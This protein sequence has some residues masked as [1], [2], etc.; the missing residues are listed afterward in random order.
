MADGK[1][2]NGFKSRKWTLLS[3]YIVLFLTVSSLVIAI[4]S[5]QAIG[6]RSSIFILSSIKFVFDIAFSGVCTYLQKSSF[7]IEKKDR[8]MYVLLAVF[9]YADFVLYVSATLLPVGNMEGIYVGLCI[10]FTTFIE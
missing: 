7:K 9:N 5:S 4:F 2:N 10:I 1:E 6:N 8:Y 3:G